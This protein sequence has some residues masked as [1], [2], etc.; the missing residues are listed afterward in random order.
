MAN[1]SKTA[2]YHRLVI[3]LLMTICVFSTPAFAAEK[4][5]FVQTIEEQ[6]KASDIT[7]GTANS[8]VPFIPVA[9]AGSK[10]YSDTQAE[11]PNS[12]KLEYDVNSY[13][14][15][16]GVPFFMGQK[17]VL[18]LGEYLS[19]TEFNVHT[20]GVNS[21]EVASVGLPIGWLKQVKPSWQMAAF[22]MPFGHYTMLK[23]DEYWDWEYMGGVFAR[24][25]QSETLWWAFG[26]YAD[27]A[28]HDDNFYTPYV[29][30]SWAINEEW[31][32]SAIMPW[33]AISY[34]PSSDWL[35]QLGA[36]PS[37]SSWSID[38]ER[39]NTSMNLDAWD[40]GLSVEH[41]VYGNFW[42]S[43]EAGVGGFRA[44]RFSDS[45][46]EDVD[47]DFSKGAFFGVNFK[48]RPAL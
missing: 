19:W 37:S 28:E 22:V 7:F 41:R 18:V 26:V 14:Q 6:F 15:A 40:F 11:G 2:R 36:S 20:N 38:L 5:N 8:N 46:V 45:D 13:Q 29:G 43:A 35:F 42:L 48:Y 21:F 44:L 25:V 33:P 30:A 27:V 3:T 32:L 4:A 47:V 16:A 9:F 12:N 17:D 31:T 10:F 23:H 24:Y 1:N 34:A 39:N